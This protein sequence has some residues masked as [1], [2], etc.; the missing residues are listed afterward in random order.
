MNQKGF[1]TLEVIL[2]I[3]VIGILA[4]VA[5]PRFTDVTVKANTAKIQSDLATLDNAIAI[6]FMEKGK[7]PEGTDIS[8]L[9]DYVKDV[10]SLKPPTGK[11]YVG[12]N[13]EDIKGT[14][15]TL[16]DDNSEKRAVLQMNTG[17]KKAGDFSL[18]KTTSS[19]T[20]GSSTGSEGQ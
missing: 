8:V 9:S 13:Q 19:S 17:N 20:G 14:E 1:A 4:T 12:G 5:V 7:Y 3:V 6:Y 10:A 16:V 11:A 2:M 18:T 15:Y